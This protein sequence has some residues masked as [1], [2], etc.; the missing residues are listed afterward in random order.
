LVLLREQALNPFVLK[1]WNQM[2]R[3]HQ[4]AFLTFN[5][6]PGLTLESLFYCLRTLR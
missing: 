2:I 4:Q 5:Q 3:R 6:Q 1:R